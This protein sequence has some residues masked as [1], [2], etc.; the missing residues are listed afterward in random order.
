MEKGYEDEIL[1]KLID[2]NIQIESEVGGKTI[3]KFFRTGF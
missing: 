1:V 3:P 2:K